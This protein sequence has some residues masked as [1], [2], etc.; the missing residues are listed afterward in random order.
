M[1][2]TDEKL[3]KTI[4]TNIKR[5]RYSAGLTQQELADKSKISL[6]YITKI[7]AVSCNKS[8][9]ISTLNQIANALNIEITEFLKED[10]NA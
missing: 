4:S 6:S 9:S 2:L 7:E 10:L 1:F 3:Y 5:Y 8:L